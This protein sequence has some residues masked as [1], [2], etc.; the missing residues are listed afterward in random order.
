M[1][2]AARKLALAQ[3]R[4]ILISAGVGVGIVFLV[5][6]DDPQGFRWQLAA[7]G[8]LIGAM[9]FVFCAGLAWLLRGWLE[10]TRLPKW[11]AHGAVYFVGGVI[12]WL[13][14][15][16]IAMALELVHFRAS[17]QELRGYFPIAGG[18][19]VLVGLVFYAFSLLQ[20]RLATSVERL[21]EAEFAEKEIELAR[22]MQQRILP[23]EEISGEGYRIKARNLPARGVAGD[24][25]DVFSLPDGAVGVVVADVAGK[26]M[27]AGLIM[28]TAKAALP[29]LAAERGVDEVLREA[30]RRLKARLAPREFVALTYARYEPKTGRFELGNAGLP[31]P[32]VLSPNAKPRAVSA[33]GPR[34]P[35]GV[36]AEVA[37]E[38]VAGTLAPGERLLLL[39]DGLARSADA[40]RRAARLRA[41]RGAPGN[42]RREPRDHLR[43]GARGDG[44]HARRR[45]DRPHPGAD[46]VNRDELL[47]ALA[48]HRAA[49]A[50][51][52][53]SL[54]WM[55]RFV[56]GPADPFARDNPEGHVTASAVIARADGEAFLLILHRTLG[57]W[58][59]PGG[60]VESTD[61]SAFDAALRE[62]REETGIATFTAPLS[63]EIL[64]VDVHL[65]PARRRDPAHHHF[66]VRFLVTA[67]TDFDRSASEDPARPMEWRGYEEAL[68]SGVDESLERALAKARAALQRLTV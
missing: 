12:G 18:I 49:D 22:A 58:L 29:F 21:K 5:T 42:R 26:G 67:D 6:V 1:Q 65:I 15:N 30:S 14:A 68:A 44:A 8:A 64:D 3:I 40:C 24:F 55:R 66:D 41:L 57:R 31:D 20:Q 63:D 19:G 48:R 37:Y 45:L 52:Q 54:E 27:G 25:Y 39:S 10:K 62:A 35:L 50:H 16:R 38:K 17:V 11:L 2:H 34:F 13:L 28:A 47:A 51:E 59:Q 36:R 61:A 9:G 46:R 32:Y 4:D 53:E 23:P 60:H 43:L 33:P 7:Y 56:A